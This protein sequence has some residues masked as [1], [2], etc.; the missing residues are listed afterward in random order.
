MIFANRAY[1]FFFI[2]EGSI[3]YGSNEFHVLINYNYFFL[4]LVYIFETVW[5]SRCAVNFGTIQ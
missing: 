2:K 1:N 3:E 4:Q 5:W